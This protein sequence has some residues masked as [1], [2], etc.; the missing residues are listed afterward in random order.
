MKK[1]VDEIGNSLGIVDHVTGWCLAWC[2]SG[3]VVEAVGGAK[4]IDEI[5]L[6]LW[7]TLSDFCDAVPY[8]TWHA[9]DGKPFVFYNN[10]MAL[11]ALEVANQAL[12]AAADGKRLPEWQVTAMA[13]GWRPPREMKA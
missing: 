7:N 4:P 10:S 2:R 3:K 11:R 1:Y 5:N 13:H 8:A 9:D 12:L 6:V